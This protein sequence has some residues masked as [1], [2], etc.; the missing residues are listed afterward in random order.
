MEKEN[1]GLKWS[2]K[3]INYSLVT[4]FSGF[5]ITILFSR[6]FG[7]IGGKTEYNL[8]KMMLLAFLF[9]LAYALFI[10]FFDWSKKNFP[11]YSKSRIVGEIFYIFALI[12]IPFQ[13]DVQMNLLDIEP[14]IL[15]YFSG[16][17]VF[18]KAVIILIIIIISENFW[19]NIKKFYKIFLFIGLLIAIEFFLSYKFNGLSNLDFN[20]FLMFWL[21][22]ILIGG[23]LGLNAKDEKSRKSFR[24]YSIVN[25]SLLSIPYITIIAIFF[26]YANEFDKVINKNLILIIYFIF[27]IIPI[28]DLIYPIFKNFNHSHIKKVSFIVFCY[29]LYAM[30][31]AIVFMQIEPL[32]FFLVG[33]MIFYI[34]LFSI[35]I[36]S[37]K[38][39]K[40]TYFSFLFLII[41]ISIIVSTKTY[42]IP[43][44]IVNPEIIPKFSSITITGIYGT[45]FML[46]IVCSPVIFYIILNNFFKKKDSIIKLLSKPLASSLPVI[47][48][49]IVLFG[50]HGDYIDL[51]LSIIVGMSLVFIF[52][53]LMISWFRNIDI[54]LFLFK[55]FHHK[56]KKII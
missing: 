48:F 29:S 15:V 12:I 14:N 2:V 50:M 1:L 16:I 18:L 8:S 28:I 6:L 26:L 30:I 13:V 54:V 52:S 43:L 42:T 41:L 38:M 35:P 9:F 36:I 46:Y 27:M 17:G 31:I 47:S 22:I 24:N 53:F 32:N 55:H 44:N 5:S 34:I 56:I 19:Q 10:Y 33:G 7:L 25:S 40:T 23:V 21:L 51:L 39:G 4:I 20:S 11:N 37:Y 3:N 45:I 49:P